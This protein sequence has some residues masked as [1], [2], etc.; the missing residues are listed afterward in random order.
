[1]GRPPHIDSAEI[2]RA[3]RALFLERGP[4][5][6]TAEIAA[7]AGCSEGTLFRRFPTKEKLFAAAV[8][9]IEPPDWNTLFAFDPSRDLE[10]QLVEIADGV[11]AFLLEMMPRVMMMKSALQLT[12]REMLGSMDAPPPL[13]MI[14]HATRFFETARRADCCETSDPE[15]LA[16]TFLGSLHHYAFTEHSGINDL[17]PMPRATYIRHVVRHLARGV[18]PGGAS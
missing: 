1:M 4:A 5:V 14:R 7:R 6:T 17:L 12:P 11:A 18:R 10:E 15:V 2:V 8:L 13:E 9:D 3:A 16:R